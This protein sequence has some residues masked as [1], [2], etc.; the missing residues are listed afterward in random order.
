MVR[1]K[2]AEAGAHAW[3]EALP[4]LVAGLERDWGIT[5]GRPYTGGTEA[6]VAEAVRADGTP[7]V[8]KLMIPRAGDHAE[9]EIAVLRRCGGEGC[10][11]L[12]RADE[13]RG[14]M[15]LER[16][17]PSLY[18]LSV[19][20][21]RRLEILTGLARAVWRPVS[22]V[23][24]PTGAAK[25]RWL[26]AFITEHRAGASEAAVAHALACARSRERA[27]D[28]TRV[29][30]VHGDVHQWNALR[31]AGGGFKLVDP[32]G[33]RAEP[34]YDL[35]VLMREDPAELMAGDPWDRAYLLAERTGTDPRA[36]WEW[37]VAER[38]STGLSA[39]AIGL[40]LEGGRMLAAAD[41]IARRAG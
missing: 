24:L 30:L 21:E 41:A 3:L 25:A 27:H 31:T 19:P 26:A 9:H 40:Q 22:G 29:V 34:E 20:F 18:D 1:A 4:G 39:T 15:L 6:Y 36:I 13:E 7:A 14:A 37:G 28:D 11:E 5:A 23:D 35:G 17:G 12:Y 38:V 2:A 8:L 33:L 32:D 10:A 16:L